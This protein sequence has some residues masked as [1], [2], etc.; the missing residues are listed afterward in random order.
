VVALLAVVGAVGLLVAATDSSGSTTVSEA[1][2][3][4]ESQSGSLSSSS[5]VQ[6]VEEVEEKPW[7][8][9]AL[10]LTPD[11]VTIAQV[12]ADSP[13]DAAGLE[14][15]DVIEAV[16]GTEV[17]DVPDFRDQF[18]GKNVGGTVTLAISRDGQ[19][20]TLRAE[21]DSRFVDDETRMAWSLLG[22]ASPSSP[23]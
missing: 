12:I 9:V 11:G 19:R 15:G 2:S 22:Q 1:A 7:L 8:G 17:D 10:A 21:G 5:A 3:P 18:D 13:A 16:D 20:L 23:S 4:T 14:R 6:E